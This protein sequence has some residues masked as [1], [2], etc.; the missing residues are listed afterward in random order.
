MWLDCLDGV[1]FICVLAPPTEGPYHFSFAVCWKSEMIS[2]SVAVICCNADA[3]E[4]IMMLTFTFCV[5][6]QEWN[7]YCEFLFI[8]PVL[9][10]EDALLNHI[11]AIA[12][13]TNLYVLNTFIY[14]TFESFIFWITASYNR[15]VE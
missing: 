6:L 3:P 9:S 13:K 11:M 5:L 1:S 2:Q 8:S 12:L 14:F 15:F 10:I 4:A 7:P